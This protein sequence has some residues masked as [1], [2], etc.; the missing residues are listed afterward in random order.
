M[1]ERECSTNWA[2]NHWLQKPVFDTPLNLLFLFQI[3]YVY[4]GPVQNRFYYIYKVVCHGETQ[5]FS[6]FYYT[7]LLY[8]QPEIIRIYAPM[9]ENL[10]VIPASMVGTCG[11]LYSS[12]GLNYWE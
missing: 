3:V 7:F 9:I 2:I 1:T 10:G 5:A 11:K 4:Q 6:Y 8:A 12:V